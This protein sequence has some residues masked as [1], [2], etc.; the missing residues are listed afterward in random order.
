MATLHIVSVGGT[1]HKVLTSLIHLAACGAFR[2]KQFGEINIVSID[3][4]NANG[5]LARTTETFKNYKKFYQAVNGSGSDLIKIDSVVPDLNI[6]LF[7]GDKKSL[8]D[9]FNFTNLHKTAEEELIQF[10]YTNEE[11]T[12]EFEEGF[13]GHTSVGAVIVR[14]ILMEEKEDEEEKKKENEKNPARKAWGDFKKQ[15]TNEDQIVVVGSIFGGTGA[16]CIPV[17]LKELED[18]KKSGTG[19]ATV[20]LTPYFQAVRESDAEGTTRADSNKLQ[21]DSNNF[22]IK[23][24]AALNYYEIEKKLGTTHA[25]YIIGEPSANY[26]YEIASRGNESQRNK[27]HPIELFAATAI[28]DFVLNNTNRR[29]GNLCVAKRDFINGEYCYTW[30]MLQDLDS[31]L[32]LLMQTFTRT[33]IFYN[34]VL[35]PQLAVDNAAGIWKDYYRVSEGPLEKLEDEKNQPYYKNIREYLAFFVEWIFELH[36]KNLKEVDPEAQTPRLKWIPDERVK[37]L[38]VQLKDE[39]FSLEGCGSGKIKNFEKLV[40]PE[41]KEERTAEEILADLASAKPTGKGFPALFVTLKDLLQKEKK[42]LFRRQKPVP[43]LKTEMKNYLSDHNK[44][45]FHISPRHDS[46][47]ALCPTEDTLGEIAIG[48]PDTDRKI[49]TVNDVSIP[50]PWSIFITNEMSLTRKQFKG[51]NEYAYNQWCGL[52]ALLVLRHLNHYKEHHLDVSRL[53][54]WKDENGRFLQIIK[55]LNPPKND[56]FGRQNPNWLDHAVVKLGNETI[57]FLAHNTLVCPVFSMSKN[58]ITLLHN[59]APTIV[60]TNGEFLSP[61]E[62]FKDQNDSNNKRSKYALRL[63]LTQLQKEIAKNSE[64]GINSD[65]AQSIM[66]LLTDYLK[67]LGPVQNLDQAT[68]DSISLPSESIN[69]VYDVFNT[70]CIRG[71]KIDAKDLPFLLKNTLQEKKVAFFSRNVVGMTDAELKTSYVTPDLLYSQFREDNIRN[72][73]SEN[74]G[75]EI[76]LVYDEDLLCDSMMMR[77]KEQSGEENVFH[78]LPDPPGASLSGYEVVWPVSEELLELYRPDQLNRMLKIEKN[79]KGVF[80]TL[81]LE[82]QGRIRKHSVTKKYNIKQITDTS[83]GIDDVGVCSIFETRRLPFWAV[84]PYAKI[85]NNRNESIWK[86]Y[87]FFCVDHVYND[88][89]VF[90]IE[91]FFTGGVPQDLRPRKLSAINVVNAKEFYYRHCTELPAA[92]RIIE[93]TNGNPVYRGSIFLNP[94]EP[95]SLKTSTWNVG[96]DFGTTSTSVFYNAGSD[97]P[98]FLQLL[99]EYRWKEGDNSKPEEPVGEK[100]EASLKILCNSGD[101]DYLDQY[102]ID[103]HCLA[104][105]GYTTTFEELENTAD[106][107]DATLFDSGRIFWHNYENFKNVNAVEGRREHLKNGIKWENDKKWAARYLNQLLTQITYRAIEK[108]AGKIHWFF[109]YPT[110]FSSDDQS[111]FKERLKGLIKSLR[112]DTG[113]KDDEEETGLK[114]RFEDEDSLLTESVAAALFFRIKNPEH[115]T[116]LC[117]D[118]GGGTSD[119]SIWVNKDLK[120]QTSAKFASRDM[121][122]KPMESLLERPSVLDMVCTGDVSDG[123]HTMLRS[124]HKNAGKESIPFLIETVLFEY[125]INFRNRLNELQAE[126]KQAFHNFIYLVYVAYAGLFFYLA[127]LVVALLKNEF[128]ADRIDRDITDIVIGL[129]GKGSKLTEWIKNYCKSVYKIAEEII[130]KETDCDIKF[131]PKF[132]E[133]AAKTETAY[134]LICNL[135][136]NG[137]QNT[138]SDR[139]RPKIFMGCGCNVQTKDGQDSRQFKKDDLVPSNDAFFK[140]PEKLTV[141]F[142]ESNLADFD[143][144]IEFLDRIAED[145]DNEVEAVPREWY[146]DKEKKSLLSKMTNYFNNEVL[147]RDHRFDPPFIVMLKEFLK[148]Y[149]EYLYGKK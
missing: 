149:S 140:R 115:S 119:I 73:I 41:E 79:N 68:A 111:A 40:Y 29:S 23:A 67:D 65:I 94:P 143:E 130:K 22:N 47:W 12:A 126:D 54:D 138:P 20:I 49:Y 89:P 124:A 15:I 106:G 146:N 50:S 59:F 46:L 91:P 42:S 5:N 74:N 17:V 53:T 72:L 14:D 34:K 82:I 44:V 88:T 135:N 95:K 113:L 32:P 6:S 86:R 103:K 37:L 101:Q 120:F 121:F 38:N 4:D 60:G 80:V 7:Q 18:K 96:V 8:R 87:T 11:I 108:G 139:I 131:A 102:F 62:Y 69:S 144:F 78:S 100:L 25:L 26:S 64:K 137:R 71:P 110:A 66:D 19:L 21:P 76:G 125:I 52:I 16:S 104:Q 31:D 118:I 36:K 99:N 90:T 58:A 48:L 136:E 92:L 13:Y 33:A 45:E 132:R 107:A 142:D 35:Y 75:K 85:V 147:E 109:S 83:R 30:Q 55:D 129:S 9:T 56:I 28:L 70:L 51:L 10:L 39:R 27:A 63:V 43:E 148:E 98:H 127:N 116:F 77:K 123:I 122:I 134:G 93:Q 97:E 117:L 57:A 61:K 133:N 105:K 81:T 2:S 112:E 1:G 141:K 84:W 128:G 24:K 3:A 114:H 145:A